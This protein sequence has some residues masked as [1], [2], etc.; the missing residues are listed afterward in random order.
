MKR[1]EELAYN[2]VINYISTIENEQQKETAIKMTYDFYKFGIF[3][4]KT[5][6]ELLKYIDKRF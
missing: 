3:K 2:T 1:I 4:A 5:K 6:A